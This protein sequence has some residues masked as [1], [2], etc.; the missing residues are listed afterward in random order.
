MD[1]VLSEARF[2]AWY[3]RST[4][5]GSTGALEC[6]RPRF[7]S[8]RPARGL[9]R[10][11]AEDIRPQVVDGDLAASGG[12]DRAAVMGRNGAAPLHPLVDGL[13]LHADGSGQGG[14]STLELLNHMGNSAHA[15]TKASL[16]FKVNRR[17]IPADPCK[18]ASSSNA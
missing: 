10:G 1:A 12:L 13:R 4:L 15:P 6:S 8:G 11:F 18:A 2:I 17:F 14:L 16:Q 3:A 7:I 5:M 9:G